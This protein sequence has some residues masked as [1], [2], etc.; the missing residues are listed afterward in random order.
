MCYGIGLRL[1][2]YECAMFPEHSDQYTIAGVFCALW[3]S[4]MRSVGICVLGARGRTK[5]NTQ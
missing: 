2:I 1:R 3:M 4:A 5:L